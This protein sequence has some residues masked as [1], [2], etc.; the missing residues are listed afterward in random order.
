[1]ARGEHLK[2]VG[3]KFSKDY[4]PAPEAKSAGRRKISEF[5]EAMEFLS[6]QLKSIKKFGEDEVEF[7]LQSNIVYVV[8]DKANKGDLNAVKI[9]S[10]WQGW[11]KPI[12]TA[13]TDTEGNDA[14]TPLSDKQ[15]DKIL[16]AIKNRKA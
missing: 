11:N 9:L 1:M 3:V 12:K 2:D 16:N 6:N 4:Q 8:M 14:K 7:T 10:D 15:V 5:K 13:N